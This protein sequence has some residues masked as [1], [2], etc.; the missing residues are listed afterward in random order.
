MASHNWKIIFFIEKGLTSKIYSVILNCC[1]D[2]R[3]V[4]ISDW[5]QQNKGGHVELV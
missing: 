5:K 3:G 1:R 4:K 2:F